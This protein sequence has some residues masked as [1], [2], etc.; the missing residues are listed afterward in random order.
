[1]AGTSG[2]TV[3]GVVVPSRGAIAF[4]WA[5]SAAVFALVFVA[6]V[7]EIELLIAAAFLVAGQLTLFVPF[8]NLFLPAAALV[9]LV[10]AAV[11]SLRARSWTRRRLALV[12]Q[13]GAGAGAF[14]ERLA[15]QRSR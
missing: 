11:F 8:Q 12:A 7:L 1:M 15:Q 2:R 10:V 13:Y 3:I 6:L 4:A 14:G 9:S 5:A